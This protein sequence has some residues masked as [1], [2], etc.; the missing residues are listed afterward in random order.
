MW[1]LDLTVYVF[2]YV[3]LSGPAQTY[4]LYYLVS[5]LVYWGNKVGLAFSN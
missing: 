2:R 3:W 5:L 4:T 1:G